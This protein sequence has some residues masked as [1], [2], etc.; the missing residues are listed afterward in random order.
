MQG[1]ATTLPG[2]VREKLV[3]FL[4]HDEDGAPSTLEFILL[5]PVFML[6]AALVV[7]L[8][9]LFMAQARLHDV[10]TFATRSWAVGT[11]TVSEADLYAETRDIILSATPVATPL[12][13]AG[14][15]TMTLSMSAAQATPFG[16]LGFLTGDDISTTV[17]QLREGV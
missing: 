16:I 7:D 11:M 14:A 17:T 12:I 5:L 1:T 10:A 13:D 6:I 15:I 3:T 9:F 2:R 8:T 4:R